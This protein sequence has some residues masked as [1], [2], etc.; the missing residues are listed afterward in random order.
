[1][2][3]RSLHKNKNARVRV[4]CGWGRGWACCSR[5]FRALCGFLA[6]EREKSFQL[7]GSKTAN[8]G[9]QDPST[10]R[11]FPCG[12]GRSP[13]AKCQKDFSNTCSLLHEHANLRD[14]SCAVARKGL[15]SPVV[16]QSRG[17]SI[18]THTHYILWLW[19]MAQGKA[20]AA[21]GEGEGSTRG[22]A[23]HQSPSASPPP[24]SPLPWGIFASSEQPAWRSEAVEINQW[25]ASPLAMASVAE[26]P[27]PWSTLADW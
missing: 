8:G 17:I 27:V 23:S 2:S 6:K 14:R 26:C 16:P 11:D 12:P 13:G 20:Q 9:G 7:R 1:M 15:L 4:R 19:G 10:V 22:G 25:I 24:L 18:P 3:K 21:V 5:K